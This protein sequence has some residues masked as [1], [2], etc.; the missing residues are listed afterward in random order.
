MLNPASFI[1]LWSWEH[2]T[3]GSEWHSAFFW[4]SAVKSSW[5]KNILAVWTAK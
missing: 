1:F 3:E 5:H 4:S 2:H